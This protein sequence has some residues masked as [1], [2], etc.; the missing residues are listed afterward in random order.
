EL[1]VAA[2]VNDLRQQ[3]VFQLVSH[4]IVAIAIPAN[5][6]IGGISAK[7]HHGLGHQMDANLN[8]IKM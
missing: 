5:D 4:L 8:P 3:V 2:R 6:G 1:L 7:T